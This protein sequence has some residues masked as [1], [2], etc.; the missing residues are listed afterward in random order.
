M[1]NFEKELVR[2]GVEL[3]ELVEFGQGFQSMSRQSRYLKQN[4]LNPQSDTTG[5][6]V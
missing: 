3:P 6:H 1:K 5:T 2:L 4:S